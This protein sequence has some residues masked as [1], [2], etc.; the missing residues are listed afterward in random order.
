MEKENQERRYRL[1]REVCWRW[2]GKA[3]DE[4]RESGKRR[5]KRNHDVRKQRESQQKS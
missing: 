1:G 3:E 4:E 2:G 5:R